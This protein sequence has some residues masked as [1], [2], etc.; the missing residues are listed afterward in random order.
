MISCSLCH[1]GL[2]PL[3]S[4][5]LCL[6]HVTSH[7]EVVVTGHVVCSHVEVAIDC[8]IALDYDGDRR[9]VVCRKAMA[10]EG[11]EINTY[12]HKF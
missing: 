8:D 11:T 2:D 10:V 1:H 7:V 5:P 9:D 4:L 3:S 12:T 6:R